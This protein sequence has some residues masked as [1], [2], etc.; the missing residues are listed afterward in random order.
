MQEA[1]AHASIMSQHV[2]PCAVPGHSLSTKVGSRP[3]TAALAPEG[4]SGEAAGVG[5]CRQPQRGGL[6]NGP[7]ANGT[8]TAAGRMLQP[9]LTFHQLGEVGVR[10]HLPTMVVQGQG[11]ALA[12]QGVH[13]RPFGHTGQHGSAHACYD[14][15]TMPTAAQPSCLPWRSA[16][17]AVHPPGRGAW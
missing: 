16:G 7:A 2:P 10:A 5:T 9:A 8:P 6:G 15:T 13:R 4:R 12:G 14:H 1:L 3:S 11:G 17:R